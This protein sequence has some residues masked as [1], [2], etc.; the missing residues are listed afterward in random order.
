M[1]TRRS[2]SGSPRARMVA[3]VVLGTMLA[4]VG[5]GGQ[6]GGEPP[7]GV[8]WQLSPDPPVMGEAMLSFILTDSTTGEAVAGAAVR[9]E[10]N[11][12][13]PG[14]KPV[15]ST[16]REVSPGSYQAP[17]TFTMGGD[18]FV[19][20]EATLPDGRV[21]HRRVDVPGVRVR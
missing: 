17:L 11:M 18:W 8:T 16:A 4:G 14:M 2:R 6:S 1:H 9:V 12:S 3:L 19:S 21:L 13:H 10:G 20:F 7:I 15:F 5:C